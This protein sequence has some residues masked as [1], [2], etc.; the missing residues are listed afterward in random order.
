MQ[1]GFI[2]MLWKNMHWKKDFS[3]FAR[4]QNMCKLLLKNPFRNTK[5]SETNSFYMVWVYLLKLVESGNLLSYYYLQVT[6]SGRHI[7]CSKDKNY[8]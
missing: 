2:H 5:P 1:Q 4:L 7:K 8:S 3:L 6:L